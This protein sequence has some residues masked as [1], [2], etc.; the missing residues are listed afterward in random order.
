MSFPTNYLSK[1][2]LTYSM[3]Y[4]IAKMSS[5]GQIVIPK[6]MRENLQPGDDLLLVKEKNSFVL[7]KMT[8]ISKKLR[9]EIEFS[10]N[11]DE[12]WKDVDSGRVTSMKI[13]EFKAKLKEW[14]K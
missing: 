3:E 4:A 6:S 1:S 13:E 8:D 11:I 9:E 7:K 12:A 10:K 14:S 2:R 5:K